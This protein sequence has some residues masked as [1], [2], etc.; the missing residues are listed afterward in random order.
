MR[1]HGLCLI[2]NESD[3]IEECLRAAVQ[4]CDHIYVLDNGSADGTWETVQRLAQELPQVVAW[5]QNDAPFDDGL[6]AQVYRAFR[7]RAEPDDWWCRLD[8]D[9]F[10]V[11][12][13][14]AFLCAL[15]ERYGIVWYASMSYYFSSAAAAQYRIDPSAFDDSVPVAER[16]R[17]YFAH[18]SEPRFVRHGAIGDW[19]GSSG[20]GWPEGIERRAAAS[21]VRILAKHYAYRS[22]QQLER[23]IATRAEAALSGKVFGHEAIQNW[24]EVV[25]PKSVREHKWRDI[26]YV[27]DAEL[28]ERGWE[29]R[30]IPVESLEYDAHD[31]RYVVNEELM[32]PIPEPPLGQ[33][34]ARIFRRLTDVAKHRFF[35]RIIGGVKRR[36]LRR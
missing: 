4:W 30:I 28:L 1:I 33:E 22:P 36:L 5:K 6:R 34:L 11:T 15:P 19:E 32:P 26:A 2:K 10:Y 13:P 35:G 16:C 29:S 8:A 17:Y 25:D 24:A 21:P 23:R 14:R 12:D 31:G 9:E 7:D 27:T 18:W 3:V 20:N